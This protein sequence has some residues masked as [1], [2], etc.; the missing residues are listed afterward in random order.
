MKI[1]RENEKS[2]AVEVW[3]GFNKYELIWRKLETSGIGDSAVG[4]GQIN[5]TLFPIPEGTVRERRGQIARS[6]KLE[7]RYR[8]ACII[9]VM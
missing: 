2:K 8:H 9:V 5:K 1:G 6:N 4:R 7:C 3:R